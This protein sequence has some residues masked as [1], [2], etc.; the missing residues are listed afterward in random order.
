MSYK[1]EILRSARTQLEKIE[2]LD[3][4]RIIDAIRS[5][6]ENPRP[7]GARNCRDVRHGVFV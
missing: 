6:A 1:I 2:A 3:R 5:L 4:H 7:S